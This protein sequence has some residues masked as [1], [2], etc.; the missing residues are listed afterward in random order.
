MSGY[1]VFLGNSLISWKTK[2]QKTVSKST[3]ESE[4]RSMSYTSSEVVWLEGLLSEIGIIVPNPII[5]YCD[6]VSAQHIAENPVF[7]EKTKHIRGKHQK[8]DIHY[9]R[10]LVQSGFVQCKHVKSALQLA[11]IVTKPLGADQH[12][13]LSSK[14][15]LVNHMLVQD[16]PCHSTPSPS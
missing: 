12:R 13:F 3:T 8:L 1:C 16:W 4:Y 11:D 2:K 15:G 10:E 6:N 14:L 5:L 7:H 9:V